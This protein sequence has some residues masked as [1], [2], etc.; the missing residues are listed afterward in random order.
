MSTSHPSITHT[1]ITSGALAASLLLLVGCG[2][3]NTKS[4]STDAS[5]PAATTTVDAA[6]APSAT[7]PPASS[8]A[9]NT[10]ADPCALLTQAEVDAAAGQ[11]LG[12]GEQTTS[13]DDCQWTNK[14]FSAS[15]DVTVSDWTGIKNAATSNGTKSP[16]PAPGIGDEAYYYPGLLYV[17]KG[18]A[19]FLLSVGWPTINTETDFGLGKATV[20]AQAVLDRL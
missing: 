3:S 11:P 14:D 7:E 17:R 5:G 18:D 20:L 19:G 12:A 10:F 9:G 15:V 6:A 16:P 8:A 13:L 1:R 4:S 2:S